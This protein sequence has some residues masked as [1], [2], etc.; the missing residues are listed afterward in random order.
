MRVT[1]GLLSCN[2]IAAGRRHIQLTPGNS[3]KSASCVAHAL[4]IGR[5]AQVKIR[6]GKDSVIHSIID[7]Q[8]PGSAHVHPL[9]YVSISRCADLLYRHP[10][11]VRIIGV[12]LEAFLKPIFTQIK[13]QHLTVL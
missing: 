2:C 1:T 4:A 6:K 7:L 8:R 10:V 13:F 3:P 9:I 5:T 12:H 11:F